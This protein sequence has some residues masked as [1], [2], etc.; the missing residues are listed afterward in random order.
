MSKV[1]YNLFLPSLLFS[2][3]LR[4]LSKPRAPG[5]F[6]LPIA[7]VAQVIVGLIVG[8]IGALVLRLRP[9]IE[10]RV[11]LV[12]TAFGNSAALPLLFA[13]AL[14]SST[15]S[16]P[17]LVSGLSFFL[18]G[19]TGLFWSFGY[20]LLT[21]K[22]KADDASQKQSGFD[23]GLFVKRVATPPLVASFAALVIGLIP[24]IRTW[25]INSPL[26]PALC[27]L[28]AGYSPAAVLILAGSL[29]KSAQ[30][31]SNNSST[32]GTS[33][34]NAG[35]LRIGRMVT[36]ISLTRFLLTPA[37]A[38][39]MVKYGPYKSQFIAL[40]VLLESVMPSAQNS[41]LILNMEKQNDAAAKVAS[42][43]LSVYIIGVIPISIALTF[44]LGYTGF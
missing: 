23:V 39:L 28:G 8:W 2:N 22:D 31:N 26:F 5:L 21:K 44:F 6:L 9:G 34:T 30:S 42:V 33:T 3:I 36:G 10:R 40:T 37:F 4:T 35:A 19:W 1:V 13:S 11:Y 17:Q 32:H 29:Y 18:L 16:Y 43:L 24:S 7:A 15:A 14:F 12:C 38:L 25:I 27:T 20:W 41:T